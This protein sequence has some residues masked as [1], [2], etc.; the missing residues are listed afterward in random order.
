MKRIDWTGKRQGRLQV[1]AFSHEDHRMIYWKCLCDCG[2][3]KL[4]A[5]RNLRSTQS[6]GCLVREFTGVL[7]RKHG[8]ALSTEYKVWRGMIGRC[9]RTTD[10]SYSNY[11]GRGIVVCSRWLASFENFYADM[12]PRPSPKH[13][14]ERLNNDGPYCLEN[15]TW[16]PRAQQACNRRDSIR[17]ELN[18]KVQCL[19]EWI[20][21]FGM[22]RNQAL[23]T[24]N[25]ITQKRLEPIEALRRMGREYGVEI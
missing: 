13:T 1:L 5:S 14:I 24:Q 3:E 22:S 6:C 8:M 25:L 4:I 17:I 15:C 19:A 12:G 11:G 16:I 21:Y 10:P 23:R 20:R 7:N 2:R 18:G 9:Y